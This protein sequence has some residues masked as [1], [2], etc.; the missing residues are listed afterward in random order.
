MHWEFRR[1]VRLLTQE[2]QKKKK[3][4]SVRSL[5]SHLWR[6]YVKIL[7]TLLADCALLHADMWLTNIKPKKNFFAH[8]PSQAATL[9]HWGHGRVTATGIHLTHMR[10]FPRAFVNHGMT[11]NCFFNTL[12]VRSLPLHCDVCTSGVSPGLW[13]NVHSNKWSTGKKKKRHFKWVT[14]AHSSSPVAV[15]L[16]AEVTADTLLQESTQPGMRV[17]RKCLL[18]HEWHDNKWNWKLKMNSK[19]NFKLRSLLPRWHFC[20]SAL[21]DL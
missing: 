9:P 13:L 10:V 6:L 15:V 14:F 5:P 11:C 7:T 17:S 2:W 3:T 19:L 21:G 8:S 1:F 4:F 16:H 20:N 18:F 12:A